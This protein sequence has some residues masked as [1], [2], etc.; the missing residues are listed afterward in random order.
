LKLNSKAAFAH[1]WQCWVNEALASYDKA[2]ALKSDYAEAF[3]NR[4]VALQGLKLLDEPFHSNS[5]KRY[6]GFLQ[7]E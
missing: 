2:A 1:E 7:S 6:Q 3:N 5:S 4:G